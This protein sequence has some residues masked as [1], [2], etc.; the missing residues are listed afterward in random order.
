LISSYFLG[1]PYAADTLEP[2]GTGT[3]G[4]VIRLD[5]VDC[6]TFLDYVEAMRTAASF[7]EF[8]ETL[9][10][11]RYRDGQV[12]RRS[13]NHF[14]YDW[15]TR[16]GTRVE[17]ITEAV[18]GVSVHRTRKHLNRKEDGSTWVDGVPGHEEE[19]VWIPSGTL[20]EYMIQQ[21]KSGDYVG[22]YTE[23]EGLDVTHVGIF[24]RS[25][26]GEYLRHASTTRG[27]VVDQGFRTYTAE[28]PGIIIFRPRD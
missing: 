12:H 27:R 11:I 15:K 25:D 3:E 22:F 17:D 4:L 7:D 21:L 14:F 19:I 16:N 13:R 24:I 10:N 6:F 9:R 26:S 1:V 23:A 18:G 5:A 2:G 28:K 8:R 20:A